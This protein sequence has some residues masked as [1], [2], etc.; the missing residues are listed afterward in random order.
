M[1]EAPQQREIERDLGLLVGGNFSP[2]ALG[3]LHERVLQRLRARPEAYLDAFERIFLAP[4]ADLRGQSGLYLAGFLKRLSDADPP[5]VQSLARRLLDQYNTALAVA[6][7][8]RE[9]DFALT[10][11]LPGRLSHFVKRLDEQRRQLRVL[12]G[13]IAR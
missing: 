12:L 2:D 13:E 8:A 11:A 7:H 6:D 3:D 9:Q 1:A 4:R 10:E 5:R